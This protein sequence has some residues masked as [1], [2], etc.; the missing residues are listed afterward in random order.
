MRP[1]GNGREV[2]VKRFLDLR[3]DFQSKVVKPMRE[4]ANVLQEVVVENHRWNG[5]EKTGRGGDERFGDAQRDSAQ[6]GRSGAA[7]AGEGV[8]DASHGSEQTDER[9]YGGG[10]SQPGN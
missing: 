3:R 1:D 8:D 9:S 2:L 4:V 7:E 10:R 6:A 5:S